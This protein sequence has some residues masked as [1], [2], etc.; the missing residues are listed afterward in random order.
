MDESRPTAPPCSATRF[1]AYWLFALVAAVSAFASHIYVRQRIVDLG[2]KLGQER[3]ARARM[4][5]DRR[6]LE[7]ELASLEAPADLAQLSRDTL[8]LDVPRDDQIIEVAGAAPLDGTPGTTASVVVPE[9]DAEPLAAA[10]PPD[11]SATT[12]E[13]V[14]LATNALGT[15]TTGANARA[16]T[17]V[18]PS[19][20]AAPLPAPVRPRPHRARPRPSAPEA[21]APPPEAAPPVAAPGEG[22]AEQPPEAPT[23]PGPAEPPAQASASE[24]ATPAPQPEVAP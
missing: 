16:A 18:S 5:N 14:T 22:P 17:A 10:P 23:A 6:D 3:A 15:G 7:L 8:G 1:Y 24:P 19:I 20:P 11:S 4:E 21:A 13:A 12:T 9:V 2:Y